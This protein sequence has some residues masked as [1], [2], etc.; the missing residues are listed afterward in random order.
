MRWPPPTWARGDG[1]SLAVGWSVG[2][3]GSSS[4]C[5]DSA[6]VAVPAFEVNATRPVPG[7]YGSATVTLTVAA[8]PPP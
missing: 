6:H 2:G 5:Q 3:S 7:S 1:S 4:P 8:A